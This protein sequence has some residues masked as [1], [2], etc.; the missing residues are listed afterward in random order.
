M[1]DEKYDNLINDLK[2]K[3]NSNGSIVIQIVLL[4]KR[5]FN[6]ANHL[7]KF[8]KDLHS[9]KGLI[10]IVCK[11]KKLLKYLKDTN[12]NMYFSILSLLELRK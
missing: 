8:K 7:K 2:L 5:I 3:K 6:L 10:D 9:K 4:S 11:R 1:S 12:E